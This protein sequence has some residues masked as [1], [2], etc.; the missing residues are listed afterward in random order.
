METK[1]TIVLLYLGG[2]DD[3]MDARK[4]TLDDRGQELSLLEQYQVIKIKAGFSTEID[5]MGGGDNRA[6]SYDSVS[7]FRSKYETLENAEKIYIA[8][9]YYHWRSIKEII[10]PK[11]FPELIQK[12]IWL[13]SGEPEGLISVVRFWTYKLLG[14]KI[15]EQLAII[16][17]WKRFIN[18]YQIPLYKKS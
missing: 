9:G 1:S 11:K 15:M 7:N 14:P 12:I 18:E 3:A 13:P 6:F 5:A 2:S 8:T 17:R 10:I 4:R 16:T